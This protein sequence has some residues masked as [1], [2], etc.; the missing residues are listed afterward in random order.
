[1]VCSAQSCHRSV[2]VQEERRIPNNTS[3]RNGSSSG[4]AHISLGHRRGFCGQLPPFSSLPP[5]LTALPAVGEGL[6][7]PRLKP[8]LYSSSFFGA[9]LMLAG[10]CRRQQNKCITF[11]CPCIAKRPSDSHYSVAE[12]PLPGRGNLGFVTEG[13]TSLWPLPSWPASCCV[14]GTSRAD[15]T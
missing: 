12:A 1:M 2:T 15:A 6:G 3:I 14:A 4:G 13:G 9:S 5:S 8:C 7:V 10:C 11:A